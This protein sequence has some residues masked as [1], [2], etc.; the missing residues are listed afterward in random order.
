MTIRAAERSLLEALRYLEV[1]IRRRAPRVR[2]NTG[3]LSV[4]FFWFAYAP[5][6]RLSRSKN[7][8]KNMT[9]KSAKRRKQRRFCC[10]EGPTDKKTTSS[11]ALITPLTTSSMSAASLGILERVSEGSNSEMKISQRTA[12]TTNSGIRNAEKVIRIHMKLPSLCTL[13]GST[14]VIQWFS[15]I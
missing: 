3:I 11:S 5:T 7:N 2:R 9:L 8:K 10:S 13:I 12:S 4:K 6:T 1:S 15:E 14:S